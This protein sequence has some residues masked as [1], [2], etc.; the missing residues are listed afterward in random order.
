MNFLKNVLSNFCCDPKRK[1]SYINKDKNLND[2]ISNNKIYN[3]KV[4]YYTLDIK[5]ELSDNLILYDYMEKD[6]NI[7]EQENQNEDRKEGIQEDK[8]ENKNEDKNED[9]KKEFIIADIQEDKK[10]DI[11]ADIQEDNKQENK[12]EDKSQKDSIL[13]GLNNIGAT[14]YMNATLQC[15]SNSEELT[16]YFLKKYPNEPNYDKKK[17]S[18]EY[19]KVVQN[20]WDKN[21]NNKPYSPKDFKEKLSEENPLFSGIAANDSKDLIIFLLERLHKEL[22]INKNENNLNNNII[23]QV[24]QLDKYKMLNIFINEFKEQYNS[25]ISDLFYGVLGITNKCTK[26]NRTKYNFQ[27]CNYVE[28]YL[29]K[30]NQYYFSI[31]KRNNNM[32]NNKNPD[33]DLYECFNYLNVVELMNG[34]NQIFCNFCHC[35]CDS[36]YQTNL[37]SSPNYLIINLNRGRGGVYECKVNFPEKL[38]LYNYIEYKSSKLQF[39]LYAVICHIGESSMEGHFVAYCK[40]RLDKKWYLYNDAFVNLCENPCEYQKGMAY[41][42]FYKIIQ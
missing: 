22:N 31:G 14:C 38:D 26:C 36:Y 17:I 23:D 19:Y 29:E 7:D 42:L 34:E 25:I 1:S 11:L 6:H 37:F 18:Y 33:I 10:E 24:I 27:V 2:G 3:I 32:F 16:N 8:K 41:I 39:E 28:F 13:I 30:I 40:N 20:L 21:N 15:M 12:Q 35:L 5:E 4:N 9:D